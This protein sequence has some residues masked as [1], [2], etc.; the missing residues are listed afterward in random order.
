PISHHQEHEPELDQAAGSSHLRRSREQARPIKSR[1][2][3][4]S[5][6][7]RCRVDR[8]R[9]EEREGKA[10]GADDQVLPSRLHR[11]LGLIET[12]EQRRG[13]RRTFHED[14]QEPEIS[15]FVGRN[16]G[17]KEQEE[18][19]IEPSQR[20][21]PLRRQM[22]E[23]PR[24]VY[25]HESK[26][27]PQAQQEHGGDTISAQIL[28]PADTPLGISCPHQTGE[29]HNFE[30][31]D[32]KGWLGGTLAEEQH[33]SSPNERNQ[34]GKDQHHLVSPSAVAVWKRR[35]AR[36]YLEYERQKFPSGKHP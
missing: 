8:E 30:R 7:H 21:E 9:A 6:S 13:E 1:V 32:D 27:D 34:Q 17:E 36:T 2:G 16:H 10:N 11:A 14:P 28:A 23:V 12:H 26:D 24:R 31:A 19:R 4:N 5:R 29:R 33:H 35:G 22:L 20:R 15:G 25:Q 18:Q 3:F